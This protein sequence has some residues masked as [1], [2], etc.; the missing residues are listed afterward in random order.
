[1]DQRFHL[2]NIEQSD[3][4]SNAAT[5]WSLHDHI[6]MQGHLPSCLRHNSHPLRR[7]FDHVG[8]EYAVTLP[9]FQF[10]KDNDSS[11]ITV[12]TVDLRR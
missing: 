5:R 4:V 8:E 1:M 10:D 6:G 12:S 9:I 11:R 2:D 3:S 7:K